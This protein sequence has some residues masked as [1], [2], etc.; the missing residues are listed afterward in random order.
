MKIS[1]SSIVLSMLVISQSVFAQNDGSCS[2]I[3]KSAQDAANKADWII[4]GDV[5][6]TIKRNSPQGSIEVSIEN[7]KVLYE[8]EKSPKFYTTTLQADSCFPNSRVTLSG[9]GAN[10]IE[11]KRMRFFG[12]KLSSGLG[13]RFYFMQSAKQEMPSLQLTRQVFEDKKNPPNVT[14]TLPDGWFRLR[15]TD[16]YFS[17]EMSGVFEDI[18]K[19]SGEQPAFMLRGT[20]KY[21]SMFL[22]VFERS[23]PGSGIGETFDVMISKPDAKLFFFKGASAIATSDRNGEKITHGLWFRVPGGT[24]MLGI[25]SNNEDEKEFIK[26][27]E[28]FFNSLTFE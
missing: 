24:F 12:T 4:E 11:G 28:R 3:T 16:G 1:I 18:T 26:S 20:D 2:K 22:V 19:G 25:T 5:I 15:S 7:A 21:G 23:G 9:K 27:K 8:K 17:V 14:A 6:N 13:R 10:E